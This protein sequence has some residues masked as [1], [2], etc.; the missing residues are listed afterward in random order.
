M[1]VIAV[2]YHVVY[3]GDEDTMIYVF[4]HYSIPQVYGDVRRLASSLEG[5]KCIVVII[6]PFAHHSPFYS[7]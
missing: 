4:S 3:D 2:Y 1:S 6:Y 5:V 7:I